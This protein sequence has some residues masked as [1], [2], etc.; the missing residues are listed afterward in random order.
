MFHIPLELLLGMTLSLNDI[1]L[2]TTVYLT[3]D[4]MMFLS[5]HSVPMLSICFV[6]S[7]VMISLKSKVWLMTFP[8]WNST[9]T[10]T[11]SWKNKPLLFMSHLLKVILLS[12]SKQK[13]MSFIK[14]SIS[15]ML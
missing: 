5:S 6:L 12:R 4:S 15:A 2:K 10:S 9:S 13:Q 3:K 11:P 8:N 1:K 7:M 14:E